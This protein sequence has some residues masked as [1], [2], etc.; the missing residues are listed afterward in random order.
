MEPVTCADYNTEVLTALDDITVDIQLTSEFFD[1]QQYN[2]EG[3]MPLQVDYEQGN[4]NSLF[5]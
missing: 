4:L 3:T 1:P 5:A 2:E